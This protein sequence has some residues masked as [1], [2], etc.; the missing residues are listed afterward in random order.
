MSLLFNIQKI[1]EITNEGEGDQKSENVSVG[2]FDFCE[3]DNKIISVILL[4]EQVETAAK[5]NSSDSDDPLLSI[6]PKRI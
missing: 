3:I 1:A 6:N 4:K 5:S 2:G